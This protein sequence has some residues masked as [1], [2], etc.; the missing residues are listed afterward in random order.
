MCT[1]P[2]TNMIIKQNTSNTH[3]TL[4]IFIRHHYQNYKWLSTI[5]LIL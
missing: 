2:N 4:A 1:G 5:G 3:K